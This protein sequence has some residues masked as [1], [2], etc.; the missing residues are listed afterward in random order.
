VGIIS[1]GGSFIILLKLLY[2]MPRVVKI[3]GDSRLGEAA[4]SCP[5]NCFRK[6]GNSFVVDPD[7]CIDCGVCQTIVEEGVIFEDSEADE[8]D[9]NFNKEKSKIWQP[10][11]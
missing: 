6:E 3:T 11:Q 8:K 2:N 4:A 1:L 5:V 9:V 7:L 10:A